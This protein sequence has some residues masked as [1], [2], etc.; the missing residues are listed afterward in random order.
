V[1]L[2]TT[3]LSPRS[4]ALR[5]VLLIGARQTCVRKEAAGTANRRHFLDLKESRVAIVHA[6]E[7]EFN[8]G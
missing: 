8:L 7:R 6:L 5:G 1:A 3:K 2:A 4:Y